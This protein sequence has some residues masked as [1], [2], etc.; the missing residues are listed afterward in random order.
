MIDYSQFREK[1]S[2]SNLTERSNDLYDYQVATIDQFPEDAMVYGLKHKCAFSKLPYF[3]VVDSFPPD[4]M[5][6]CL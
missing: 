1:L 3:K 5:H 6:N 2:I 4:V